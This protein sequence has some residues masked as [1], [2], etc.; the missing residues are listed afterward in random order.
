MVIGRHR[1]RTEWGAMLSAPTLPGRYSKLT[2]IVGMRAVEFFR[3][4]GSNLEPEGG[5]S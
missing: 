4:V 2:Q 5:R 3:D 1:H